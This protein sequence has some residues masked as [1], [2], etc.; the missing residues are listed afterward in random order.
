MTWNGL[1]TH[2]WYHLHSLLRHNWQYLWFSKTFFPPSFLP[3]HPYFYPSTRVFTR[4]HDRWTGLCIKLR[5]GLTHCVILLC[6]KV[7]QLVDVISWRSSRKWHREGG[8]GGKLSPS[9]PHQ[10]I[11]SHNHPPGQSPQLLLPPDNPE[12]LI[13]PHPA[14]DRQL[15][16]GCGNGMFVIPRELGFYPVLGNPLKGF[17]VVVKETSPRK[18][19]ILLSDQWKWVLPFAAGM[20]CGI[21]VIGMIGRRLMN[22]NGLKLILSCLMNWTKNTECCNRGANRR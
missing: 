14:I 15:R 16:R 3:V 6:R 4:P 13:V 11:H 19:Y 7:F 21:T 8:R 10:L 17:S 18:C 1:Q 20:L 5:S 2:I 9:H 12:Q 22:V